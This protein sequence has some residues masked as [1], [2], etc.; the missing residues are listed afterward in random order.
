MQCRDFYVLI[1]PLIPS[2]GCNVPPDLGKRAL[3]FVH[4]MYVYVLSDGPKILS[5]Q[6]SFPYTALT[7]WHL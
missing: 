3:Q 2:A 5:H 1:K 4:I 7:D 6:P